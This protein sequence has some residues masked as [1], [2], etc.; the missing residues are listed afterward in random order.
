MGSGKVLLII[1]LGCLICICGCQRQCVTKK[2][3]VHFPII[4]SSNTDQVCSEDGMLNVHSIGSACILSH[5]NNN[6][7]YDPDGNLI[8]Y[9]D[10]N[11]IWPFYNI[12]SDK[13][14]TGKSSSGTILLFFHFNNEKEI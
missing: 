2:D 14:E 1:G 11:G 6:R 10:Q 13:T 9:N 8:Q 12:R 5:W 4:I 7:T 3:S